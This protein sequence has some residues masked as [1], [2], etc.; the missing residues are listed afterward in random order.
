MVTSAPSSG[1][2]TSSAIA[3]G[4]GSLVP[5]TRSPGLNR[6]TAAPTAST[7][8]AM[9]PPGIGSLG[10]VSP[11]NSRTMA[12]SAERNAVSAGVT[13]DAIC[14][15]STSR[16]PTTGSGISR[17]TTTSGGP[18]RSIHAAF[19]SILVLKRRFKR[20]AEH[21]RDP[22]RH[23]ERGRVAALFDGDDGLAGHADLLGQLRLRHL[24]GMEAQR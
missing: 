14:R 24:A 9:L 17:T 7:T 19:I 8:P 12:G 11:A 4:F 18:Y 15:T 23:L 2:A 20:H 10:L 6:V 22:E 13:V 3:P 5:N 1:R 21:A 16:S